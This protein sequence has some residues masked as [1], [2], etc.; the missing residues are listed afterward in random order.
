MVVRIGTAKGMVELRKS[1]IAQRIVALVFISVTVSILTVSSIFIFTQI[2]GAIDIRKSSVEATGMVYAS[3][4]ADAVVAD[5]RERAYATLSSI[6]RVPG[7]LHASAV[8]EEGRQI[9]ALGTVV[10]ISSEDG[11]E[12]GGLMQLLETGSY[13]IAV[14]IVKAGRKAGQLVI[15]ADVSDLRS[16]L[17]HAIFLTLLSAVAASIIGIALATR[18][19][20]RISA[21]ILSLISAMSH[22]RQARD[23]TTKVAHT[24]D[25][26][27]GIL[28]DTFNGMIAEIGAHDR[29]L[30]KLAFFDTLTGLANRQKFHNHLLET[31]GRC[32]GQ[33]VKAAL[34]LFDL[35]EFKLVNDTLGHSIG[36]ELLITV[37]KILVEPCGEGTLLARLGGDEFALVA[38]GIAKESEAIDLMGRL[39][40]GLLKPIQIGQHEVNVTASIGCALIPRD[41]DTVEELLRHADLALYSAKREGRGRIHFYKGAM[42]REVEMRAVLASDLQRAEERGEL[43]AHFQALVDLHTGEVRG[44]ESLLRW[45]HRERGAIPPSL[46]IPVA[47]G[48]GQIP[49]LGLWILRETCQHAKRWLDQGLPPR[50]VSVNVSIAQLRN[51]RFADDVSAVLA[52]T[53]LPPHLLCLEMTE[54]L[55]AGGAANRALETVRSLKG[56]GAK[57]AL[58]DFGTGY[59]SLSYLQRNEFDKIKLDRAFVH[60]ADRDPERR[61]LLEG[62][63]SLGKSL[64][65]EVVAEGAET[66]GE[67]RLLRAI[68]VDCLQGFALSRPMKADDA[69]AAARLIPGEFQRRFGSYEDARVLLVAS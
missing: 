67:V 66:D 7:I 43:E 46:F 12:Q 14:D 25:D 18:L 68:G 38:E 53:G 17:F 34:F 42:A 4:V 51:S 48:T 33:E 13:T 57:L 22:I 27:T 1:R 50:E 8:D 40:A 20:A 23:Y 16:Q 55:Y 39:A 6:S 24:S 30:E 54:S 15:V 37:G 49:E 41:G 19:Q 31:I 10:V 60:E 21:P 56:L 65:F 45:T 36:D 47:E 61:M 64:G 52:E 3:A 69:I 2:R 11:E 29:Q 35:D 9:A 44:F 63:A 62:L 58:D 26:E 32:K 5:D 59:S 28:V